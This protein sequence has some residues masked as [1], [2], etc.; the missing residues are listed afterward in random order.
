MAGHADGNGQRVVH[1][2]QDTGGV[3]KGL[4]SILRERIVASGRTRYEHRASAAGRAAR[5]LSRQRGQLVDALLEE[6][7]R[8]LLLN[9]IEAIPAAV[10]SVRCR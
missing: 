7:Q 8:M 10:A 5:F 3:Q 6:G 2:M 1:S 9:F 4:R